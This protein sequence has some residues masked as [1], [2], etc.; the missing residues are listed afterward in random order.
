MKKVKTIITSLLI[1]LASAFMTAC[2]CGGN[3]V[4]PDSVVHVYETGINISSDHTSVE[5]DEETGY[6]TIRCHV[7]DEFR[8]TYDLKPSDTTTTQV[9][10]DFITN[11]DVAVSKSNS[12]T[13]SQSVNHTITFVAKKV[14]NT[15]LKFTTKATGKT[16]Q[17]TIIVGDRPEV[18]PSFVAPTGL[19][20]NP[21]TGKVTWDRVTQKKSYTGEVY[22]DATGLTGYQLTI[23]D[24]TNDITLDPV[25]VPDCEYEL[26]RGITYAVK[27]KALGDGTGDGYGFTVNNG[28]QSDEFKFHQLATAT[29][30]KNNNGVISYKTPIHSYN[31]RIYFNAEDASMFITRSHDSLKST[32]LDEFRTDETF[33][34][35]YPGLGEY[36]ISIVSYPNH[37]DDAKGYY[38][39]VDTLIRYYPSVKTQ[40]IKIQQLETPKVKMTDKLSN[41]TISNITFGEGTENKPHASSIINWS[42]EKQYEKGLYDV[43][44]GYAIYKDSIK[45]EPTNSEYVVTEGTSF[46]TSILWS[47]G[48]YVG[49]YKL[50]VY[51]LGNNSTTI[52]S[53]KVEYN[54]NVLGKIDKDTSSVV[55]N[56]IITS[57]ATACVAGVDLYF[58]NKADPTKSVY[59]FADGFNGVGYYLSSI[60]FDISTLSLTPGEYDIYGKFVGVRGNGVSTSY[61]STTGELSLITDIANPIIVAAPVAT[62][63]LS[64]SGVIKF[65]AVPGV[66]DYE[67]TINQFKNGLTPTST[68]MATISK[69]DG[70]YTEDNIYRSYSDLRYTQVGE[71]NYVSI[72]DII[73]KELLRLQDVSMDNV[74]MMTISFTTDAELNFSIKS[75]GDSQNGVDSTSS[76]PVAF[77]RMIEVT[78]FTLANNIISFESLG[79]NIRY[80]VEINGNKFTIPASLGTINVD[81]T[82][83]KVGETALLET[84][85]NRTENL[86]ITIS[87][88]GTTSNKASAGYLDSRANTQYFQFTEKPMNV[89]AVQD[90]TITWSTSMT[91]DSKA[92]NLKIY[93]SLGNLLIDKKILPEKVVEPEPEPEPEEPGEEPEEPAGV[94]NIVEVD[95]Y[96]YNISS[97]I[98]ECY[99]TLG[100]TDILKI[101]IEEVDPSKLVGYSSDAY[102]VVKLP[103]VTMTKTVSANNPSIQFSKLTYT[104]DITYDISVIKNGDVDNATLY[105]KI[106]E[107]DTGVYYLSELGVT[108]VANYILTIMPKKDNS[109]VSNSSTTPF[110]ISGDTTQIEVSV[111]SSAITTATNG[112]SITWNN[113]HDEATY[114][115]FYKKS[116]DA[117]FTESEQLTLTSYE[118]MDLF[119]SGKYTV[120]I[121]PTISYVDTGIV[122]I[123]TAQENTVVKLSAPTS[124]TAQGLITVIVPAVEV[125]ENYD[126]LNYEL[127]LRINGSIVAASEYV[128]TPAENSLTEFTIRIITPSKYVDTNDIM[129]VE[130][131]FTSK[132]YI[133]SDFSSVYSITAL[134]TAQAS[135]SDFV[136]VGEWIEWNVIAN[137]TDYQL[138]FVK[139]DGTADPVVVNL[140]YESGVIKYETILVDADDP[141]IITK[142]FVEDANVVKIVNGKI[143]YKFNEELVIPTTNG[144]GEYTYTV[145]ASTTLPGYINGSESSQLSITKL[146]EV[147]TVSTNLDNIVLNNYIPVSSSQTPQ[148]LSYTIKYVEIEEGGEGEETI[149]VKKEYTGTLPYETIS[150]DIQLTEGGYSINVTSLGFTEAGSY[151]V[152]LQFIGNGDNILSSAELVTTEYIE[153]LS[154][155]EVRTT[156]GVISWEMIEGASSYSVKITDADGIETRLDSLILTENNTL[157]ELTENDINAKLLELE[158]PEF[159]FEVGKDYTVQ[160]MSNGTGI[161]SSN[162]STP[163][164]VK[165]LQSPT[166]IQVVS[167]DEFTY[168]DA[169]GTVITVKSGDSMIKWSNPNTVSARLNFGLDYGDGSEETIIYNTSNDGTT[170]LLGQ[171]LLSDKAVGSYTLRMRTIGTTTTGTNNIGLLSSNYADDYA[172]T[173]N[174]IQDTS[175]VGMANNGSYTW[176]AVTGAYLYK[177]AFYK[178]MNATTEDELVY[179]TYTTTNSYSFKNS[180]FSTPG[181]YTLY[182]NAITDPS[183]AIVST[184]ESEATDN[185][186][187]IYKSTNLSSIFV[188]DGKL[189][190]RIAVSDIRAF[191]DSYLQDETSAMNIYF[192]ANDGQIKDENAEEQ[193]P[194]ILDSDTLLNR[195]INYILS[196]VNQDHTADATIDNALSHLYNF[197]LLLNGVETPVIADEVKVVDII[198]TVD[199]VSGDVTDRTYSEV[200]NNYLDK[201][202]LMFTYDLPIET[203]EEIKFDINIAPIGSIANE[204]NVVT[205]TNGSYLN[206]LKLTAY[207]PLTPRTWVNEDYADQI[208]NG[209]L[210][211]SLVTTADST[212]D[213]FKYHENYQITAISSENEDAQVSVKVSTTETYDEGLGVNTNITD[214]YNYR[215]QL[216]ELFKT[217]GENKISTNINYNLTINVLGTLDST[218]LGSDDKIYLNSNKFAFRDHLNILENLQVKVTN[219]IFSWDY[220]IDSTATKVV[221]YGPFDYAPNYDEYVE[222]DND[223][224]G[225][226]DYNEA[227]L[228]WKESIEDEFNKPS[229][230]KEFVY[231][232]EVD[233]DEEG[234]ATA[235]RVTNYSLTKN[236]LED[237]DYAAG[238]YII[239]KQ[240][241]GNGKGV[242]DT[243]FTDNLFVYEGDD[244]AETLDNDPAEPYGAVTTKLGKT[245][246][247]Y[248]NGMWVEDGVFK[249]K[250]VEHA[251]AYS[252][253]L[254]KLNATG[255]VLSEKAPVIVRDTVYEMPNE[256]DYN[257][258]SCVYRIK[259]TSLRVGD[260]DIILPNYF[261]GDEVVTAAYG[262][263]PVPEK[264]KI[265]GDGIVTWDFESDK[266]TIEKYLVL[267]NANHGELVVE[268]DVSKAEKSYDLGN[269]SQN[270]TISIM[271]KSLAPAG[272]LNSCFTPSI[273]VTKL[274][275][276]DAKVRNGVFDWLTESGEIDN[277]NPANTLFKLYYNDQLIFTTAEGEVDSGFDINVYNYILNTEIEDY[278]TDYSFTS[279]QPSGEYTFV[280]QFKGDEGNVSAT[281]RNFRITSSPLEFT[282]TKL[283]APALT[284]L[285]FDSEDGGVSGNKIRWDKITGADG[286]RALVFTHDTKL[287]FTTMDNAEFFTINENTV[288][289]DLQKVVESLE[290]GDGGVDL[291][292]YVQA[293]GTL[294][295]TVLDPTDP[296]YLN[297]SYSK[298]KSITI[299]G[300]PTKGYYDYD[301][302]IVS[303]DLD[304][305]PEQHAI[306][307]SNKHNALVTMTYKVD[308]VT[309]D[310]YANY[311]SRTSE[312]S[313]DI[314]GEFRDNVAITIAENNDAAANRTIIKVAEDIINRF[315]TKV[316]RVTKTTEDGD[317]TLYNLEVTD[318]VF[319]EATT[320]TPTSYQLTNYG[321]EYSFSVIITVGDATYRGKYMSLPLEFSTYQVTE[322][323]EPQKINF[324]IFSGGDGSST[325][326][327]LV[328]DEAAF[329]RMRLFSHRNFLITNDIELS[330][331]WNIIDDDFTGVIDG[332]NHSITGLE[333]TIDHENSINNAVVNNNAVNLAFIRNIVGVEDESHNMIGGIVR[334]LNLDIN[335]VLSGSNYK[336]L[337]IRIGGLAITNSGVIDNVHITGKIY[338]LVGESL[339]TEVA[340]M[341]VTN[342]GTINN[343]SVTVGKNINGNASVEGIY[344]FDNSPQGQKIPTNA[345]GIAITNSG[346]ISN[347]HFSGDITSNYVAGIAGINTGIIDKCYSEGNAYASDNDASNN[348]GQQRGI[349]YGGIAGQITGEASI[350]NSYSVMKVILHK[351]GETVA[352]LGGLVGSIENVEDITI[353][354]NY[355]IVKFYYTDQAGVTLNTS[356]LS[357]FYFMPSNVT[358]SADNYYVVETGNNSIT[359]TDTSET[360]VGVTVAAD[361][362]DLKNNVD[363]NI[364]DVTGD[365][366]VHK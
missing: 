274:Q 272:Y 86:G 267:I 280:V 279:E 205:T 352:Y 141:T 34:K 357:A 139:V 347:T 283:Q 176:A 180:E 303:W 314:T 261:Q 299:P 266:E 249:W 20:Y 196:K 275:A 130:V 80:I 151:Q 120:K 240:E 276:P 302:G 351:T 121:V 291:K 132:G 210:L 337:N 335:Y 11:D 329:I 208:T 75:K 115:V 35:K 340:G 57:T 92:F 103:E 184:L 51:T 4:D 342:N 15:V 232:A 37:F 201:H 123:G 19:D 42:I 327:Y 114:K 45:I 76:V 140:R 59:Q 64:S 117:T 220:C 338:V 250:A 136:K 312:D 48:N 350:T 235:N 192:T 218:L 81:L 118:V 43:K 262:R 150:S 341:V 32:V 211:W 109:Q 153:R 90:G 93:D 259:I 175:S 88:I 138:K 122:L 349:V 301:T 29:E 31:N 3:P 13:Y 18:L 336:D 91:A 190:W 161:L 224:E 66:N 362:D 111:M 306:K 356:G 270:G 129:Q 257:D 102:Y 9:D 358:T 194:V 47:R 160:V 182:V 110:V 365:Y 170:E 242:I 243:P 278:Y 213:N 1:V 284:N 61:T 345:A 38:Q 14:G 252:I 163:F 49:N 125:P 255:E 2:S 124:L 238:S 217:V 229:N 311:W 25:V 260:D 178:G 296:V 89:F 99:A 248:G 113:L 143:M 22:T 107:S 36:N 60:S 361:I 185:T 95:N 207:K 225:I 134:K 363:K 131:Q 317:V 244:N 8:I 97:I 234:N 41:A 313:F 82:K 332:G 24:L 112:T 292:I 227:L 126:S 215:R 343:S 6:L 105:N 96:A 226:A 155:A 346:T 10:W 254:Q 171:L 239:R 85:T 230:R 355:V 58:I 12:Y 282:A 221:I 223:T 21:E 330:K 290:I 287:V 164:T 344:A 7:N 203:E 135:E 188:K 253:T 273:E 173:V 162:W 152:I 348:S 305:D 231:E 245:D 206:S 54:F 360:L 212:P 193:E 133:S 246:T 128:V 166:N 145:I 263:A 52:Q 237:V 104:E 295:S 165:K 101:I 158:Q 159:T 320:E 271:I 318:V 108:D 189:S 285:D 197:R 74:E 300:K 247:L 33:E 79:Q 251:N 333:M 294:D 359:G 297:S 63:E 181:Y 199:G 16:T 322:N 323:S 44:F 26:P 307:L 56:K 316:T 289:L 146:N 202:F 214:N 127:V 174:Y 100:K 236:L 77:S 149:V 222:D 68:V 186:D 286:Y 168:T 198:D 154:T 70:T 256:L 5:V 324:T 331:N 137:A 116:N 50:V 94:E 325:L 65:K 353:T 200:R 288:D 62:N 40:S 142:V 191:T 69:A 241:I 233:V 319:L 119:D 71:Y 310:D 23:T 265:D 156:A 187:I 298:E 354:N 106:L 55:D 27:V 228:A 83:L 281:E 216:T 144:A 268:A 73:G 326:P 315:I 309:A 209:E 17:A 328:S 157:V 28:P 195:T 366:P 204:E 67:I 53:Q 169:E 321:S 46:D 293:I 308:G 98:N 72:Y 172:P 364:Y 148:S 258:I 334:N 84:I 339:G 277:Q 147:V 30:L 78:D 269:I 219:S 264:L 183:V 39:D 87:A 177:L 167:A 304:S 179:I